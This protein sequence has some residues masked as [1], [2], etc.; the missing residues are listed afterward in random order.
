MAGCLIAG[1]IKHMG[2]LPMEF[3]RDPH[4]RSEEVMGGSSAFNMGMTAGRYAMECQGKTDAAIKAGKMKDM[5]VPFEAELADGTRKTE[6]MD[7]QP[8][9]ET[10]LEGLA[11]LKTPFKEDGKITAGKLRDSMMGLV[12]SC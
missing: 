12:P 4:P 5:I 2:H 7:Q 3:M 8:R 11:G 1:G 10:I 9:P 6:D